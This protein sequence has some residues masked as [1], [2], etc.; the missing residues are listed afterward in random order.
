MGDPQENP[1]LTD[2]REARALLD[3]QIAELKRVGWAELWR[4]W[5]HLRT[6]W[7]SR[8]ERITAISDERWTEL[9]APSGRPYSLVTF[10]SADDSGM[11]H[12]LFT[13]HEDDAAD[14]EIGD[15]LILY[16]EPGTDPRAAL[17]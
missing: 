6:P 15:S 14:A 11:L 5:A 1:H 10:A 3:A 4:Q 17:G 8:R 9:V 12:L 2:P 13:L 7:F 16:P